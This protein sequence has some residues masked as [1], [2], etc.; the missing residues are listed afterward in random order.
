MFKSI[1]P[2][3]NAIFT[4]TPGRH[5]KL[6]YMYYK[7]EA[8]VIFE[9]QCQDPPL[10]SLSSSG[11]TRNNMAG[12]FDINILFLIFVILFITHVQNKG[13]Q[14]RKKG[15]TYVYHSSPFMMESLRKATVQYIYLY[16]S[17]S[18]ATQALETVRRL[19]HSGKPRKPNTQL[20]YDRQR[21]FIGLLCVQRS[22]RY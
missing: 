5:A 17:I 14:R 20:S 16:S 8:A 3:E 22:H 10:L 9:R 12:R 2:L 7:I 21:G 11:I 15:K 1:L 6:P 18:T 4:M 13:M 19:C